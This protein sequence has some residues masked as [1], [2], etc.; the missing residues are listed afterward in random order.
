VSPVARAR[1]LADV[2][3][4]LLVQSLRQAGRMAVAMEARGFSAGAG[5][6][7]W[8]EPAPWTRFD[9]AVVALGLAV[10]GIPVLV[11]ALG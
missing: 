5:R 9:S 4:A 3:F 10:T 2:T 6:R 8:A 1:H 11:S 7:T